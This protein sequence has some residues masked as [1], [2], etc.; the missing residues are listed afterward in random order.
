[1]MWSTYYVGEHEILQ[2]NRHEYAVAFLIP[3]N[4]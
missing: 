3:A 1:M 2:G 4:V